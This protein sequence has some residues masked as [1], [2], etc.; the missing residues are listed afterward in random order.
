MRIKQILLALA[1][2]AFSYNL[3]VIIPLDVE[4]NIVT[5]NNQ[6]KTN[7][8]GCWSEGLPWIFSY[9]TTVYSINLSLRY[10][11]STFKGWT[12][13][14]KDTIHSLSFEKNITSLGNIT[15]TVVPIYDTTKHVSNEVRVPAK[16]KDNAPI[17][18]YDITG[19]RITNIN[20]Y[21]GRYF[22]PKL[23]RIRIK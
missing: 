12:V 2:S 8:M 4:F 21:N 19:R 7:T 23:K 5:V 1:M 3:M 16:I 17:I 15:D 10:T 13:N 20:N 6:A 14:K 18:Y 11:D 9:D 22:A